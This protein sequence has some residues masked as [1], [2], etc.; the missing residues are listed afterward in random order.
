MGRMLIPE[1]M[2]SS[3]VV[4]PFGL[5][6]DLRCNG[7]YLSETVMRCVCCVMSTTIGESHVPDASPDVR[8]HR[9]DHGE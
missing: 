4:P 1:I 8:L 6:L 7:P 9:H 5:F 3:A 2:V